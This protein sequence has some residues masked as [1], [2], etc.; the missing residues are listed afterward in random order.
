MRPVSRGDWQGEQPAE[1]V[2]RQ[3]PRL[4]GGADVRSAAVARGWA[5]RLGSGG[6]L[7]VEILL[8]VKTPL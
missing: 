8:S 1:E 4:R 5:A 3:R 6:L 2:V 7:E